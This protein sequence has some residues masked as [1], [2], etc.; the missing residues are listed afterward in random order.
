MI[1]TF[2]NTGKSPSNI[3]LFIKIN[4]E[5]IKKSNLKSYK[6]NH[7]LIFNYKIQTKNTGI[8]V[9]IYI[10]DEPGPLNSNYIGAF[11]FDFSQKMIFSKIS[12]STKSKTITDF[13]NFGFIRTDFIFI[14]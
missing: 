5:N 4:I 13:V 3:I 1:S 7:K 2:K 9:N 12:I 14:G 11:I 6:V 8:E 10:K